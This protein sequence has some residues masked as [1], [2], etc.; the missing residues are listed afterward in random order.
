MDIGIHW[1][2]S[3]ITLDK[4]KLD[5]ENHGL[6]L[7]W[8]Q[9]FTHGPRNTE[10]NITP[11]IK[12]DLENSGLE[13]YV[14]L[15]YVCSLINTDCIIDHLLTCDYINAKGLVIHIPNKY[16]IPELKK[17]LRKIDKKGL[18]RGIKTTIYL[19]NVVFK[20]DEHI[21]RLHKL[22]QFTQNKLKLNYGI[23]LDTCHLFESGIDIRDYNVI[24]QFE[25]YDLIFH[26]NDSN[27]DGRDYH[28]YL[29]HNIWKHDNSSLKKIIKSGRPFILERSNIGYKKDLKVLENIKL[30]QGQNTHQ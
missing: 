4:L 23:C 28:Q 25:Q 24:E 9:M 10:N 11:K 17:N 21:P 29:G 18:K 26:L 6:N 8:I 30:E 16:D 3:K 22:M 7:R 12:Q 1:D 2:R 19:E 20:T 13:V 27:G 15:C 5:C 14:H